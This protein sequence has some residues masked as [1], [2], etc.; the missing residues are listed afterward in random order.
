MTKFAWIAVTA[1]SLVL[2]SPAMAVQGHHRHH[3]SLPALKL[4]YGST[5]AAFGYY[6]GYDFARRNNFN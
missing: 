5:Y 1:L 2:A 3:G 4:H 6:G